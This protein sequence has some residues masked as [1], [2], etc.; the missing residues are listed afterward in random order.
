MY[1]VNTVPSTDDR[2]ILK[3]FAFPFQ[4]GP[5]GFPAMAAPQ[6]SV[7]AKIYALLTTGR[8]ERVMNADF[9]VDLYQYVF[10]T[11]TPIQRAR[12]ANQVANAIETF[13]AGVIVNNISV[14]QLE[15]QDGIGSKIQFDIE[16]TVGGQTDQQQVIYP[17]TAQ[18]Q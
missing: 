5:S 14:G 12:V 8:G 15:Y 4:K 18:G 7:F 17:P 3:T 13:I 2:Q 10:S 16:Y 11:M 9:G 1:V 6:G